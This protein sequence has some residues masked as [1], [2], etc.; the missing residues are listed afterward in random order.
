M[1]LL[2]DKDKIS[3]LTSKTAE[4]EKKDDGSEEVFDVPAEVD[5][6]NELTNNCTQFEFTMYVKQPVPGSRSPID[7]NTHDVGHT[8]I[9]IS[10]C[11][12][13]LTVGFYPNERVGKVDFLSGGYAKDIDG[14]IL[15]DSKTGPGGTMHSWD[16]K[17]T[18]S[19]TKTQVEKVKKCIKSWHQNNKYNL[20]SSNCTDFAIAMANCAGIV[21]PS[22]K[23]TPWPAPFSHITSANPGDMGED[24]I[25]VGGQRNS[26]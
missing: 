6:F 10:G 18:W 9:Q 8:F 13:S 4:K 1:K 21:V 20:V 23:T 11:G 3:L 16:V 7:T 25:V 5:S 17:M 14:I 26:P 19:I 12:I 22:G 24:L 15:D 2:L